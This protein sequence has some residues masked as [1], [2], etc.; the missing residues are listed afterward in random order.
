[1]FTPQFPVNNDFVNFFTNANNFI[2]RLV[3]DMAELIALTG[4][5]VSKVPQYFSWLPQEVSLLLIAAFGV[6]VLYMI[7]GRN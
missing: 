7:L 6:V 1:M 2:K 5:F 3:D 4:E